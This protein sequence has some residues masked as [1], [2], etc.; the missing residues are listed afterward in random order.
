MHI[1]DPIMLTIPSSHHAFGWE[2]LLGSYLYVSALDP[3]LR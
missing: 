2:P 3:S 1:R